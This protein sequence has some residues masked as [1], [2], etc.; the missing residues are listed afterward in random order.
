MKK[1]IFKIA[2][3][4][5]MITVILSGC[6]S[7][8]QKV[9]TATE[10]LNEAKQELSHIQKDSV[11]DYEIF[12]HESEDKIKNNERLIAEFK[13]KMATDKKHIK[14][15]DQ[16]IIDDLEQ[17]NINMRKKIE[18]YRVNGKDKWDT[19]KNE[20]NHDLEGLGQAINDITVKNTK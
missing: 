16:K 11:V 10:N 1:A 3:A 20:F 17:Q 5:C 4:G 14:A 18:D 9:E 15:R 8:S 12:R 13:A 19:F 7:P 2:A 6:S